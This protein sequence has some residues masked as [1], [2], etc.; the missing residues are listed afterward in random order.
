MHRFAPQQSARRLE[1]DWGAEG[2]T[3]LE[4]P[5]SRDSKD[6][7]FFER[8]AYDGGAPVL[9]AL[10]P[11]SARFS[12]RIHPDAAIELG[13]VAG[14]RLDTPINR[15]AVEG[16]RTSARLGPDEW[17]LIGREAEN[18]MLASELQRLVFDRPFS[19][20]DIGH[21]NVALSVMGNLAREVI[22]G[23]CPI[24]LA[25]DA[26]PA[27]SASRSILGKAEVVLM[28]PSAERIYR[29]EC[30]RSFV[31]YVHALLKEAAQEY[32]GI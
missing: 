22:N 3:Y 16:Q 1:R 4:I 32:V 5:S 21:R 2:N 23:G 11:S 19:L 17:F 30:G 18:E 14:F 8:V 6:A 15:C 26:F 29:I 13:G 31:P 10:L 9:I 28:R 12:L 27:G 25:D 7:D 20:V 24:N